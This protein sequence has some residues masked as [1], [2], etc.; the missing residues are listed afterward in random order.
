M[1]NDTQNWYIVKQET[2]QCEIISGE[3]FNPKQTPNVEHWGP[4]ASQ[5]DA[6]A[7]RV[8]LIR[9]GKCQPR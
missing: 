3:I 7:R 1:M 4:F 9:A 5:P 2:G 6:I 8:G